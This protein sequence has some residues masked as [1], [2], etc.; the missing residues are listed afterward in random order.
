M[1]MA[2]LLLPVKKPDFNELKNYLT[3]TWTMME[4]GTQIKYSG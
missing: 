4:G 1:N 2:E 3:W